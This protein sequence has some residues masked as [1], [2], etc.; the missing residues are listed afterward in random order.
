M[1]FACLGPLPAFTPVAFQMPPGATDTHSHVIG[2]PPSYP[3]VA[4]RS[5]TPP[6]APLSAYMAMHK[7]LGI[8]R[9]VIVTPS[10]HGTDNRITLE[11][12][13]GYGAGARGIAVVGQDISDTELRDLH[14]GGIRGL[15]LNVLFGSGG[16]LQAFRPLAE[17][18]RD[19]GWHVQLL[20]DTSRDL[21]GLESD[22]RTLGVPVVIDHMGHFPVSAGLNS[23]EFK[24]MLDLVRD[25]IAWVK[26]SGCDR[27]SDQHP[28]YSDAIPRAQMLIEAGPSQMVWGTDWPHVSKAE[29]MPDTGEL[30]NRLADYAPDPELRRAILVDNPARLYGFDGGER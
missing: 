15:R 10:V 23:P 6:E 19:M 16:G 22:I 4:E 30:L 5:Y 29:N 14:D 13:S 7:A 1:T 11:A 21:A 25:G 26:L 3:F 18:I 27:I 12:I 8:E 20:I 17:R 2:L 28:A 9:A 24:L